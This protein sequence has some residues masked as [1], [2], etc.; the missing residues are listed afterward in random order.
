MDVNVVYSGQTRTDLRQQFGFL[1]A[2]AGGTAGALAETG[3]STLAGVAIGTI[4]GATL[5]TIIGSY[6]T[7]D[8][9]IVIAQYNVAVADQLRGERKTTIVFGAGRTEDKVERSNVRPFEQ[10]LIS[11]ISVFA[12]G[13]N[14][15]QSRIADQ[16]RQRFARILSDMI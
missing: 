8:T 1:G 2:T 13:R 7:E 10:R 9:Y 16:V 11:G 3:G 12:G 5:G 15:P 14:T 4:S 6:I